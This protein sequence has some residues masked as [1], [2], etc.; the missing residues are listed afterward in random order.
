MRRFHPGF[1]VLSL[2]LAASALTLAACSDTTTSPTRGLSPSAADLSVTPGTNSLT[3]QSDGSTLFCT[4]E[5]SLGT[6]T[7][8]AEGYNPTGCGAGTL[9][10]MAALAVYNPGWSAPITGSDWIGITANGGP[11]SD[12]RAET[13]RYVFQETFTIPTGATNITLSLGAMADNAVAVYLN[14][15][16]L[17]GQTI[18]D[19]NAAPCN[20]TPAG[21]LNVTGSGATFFADGVTL[22]RLT[23]VLINTPIGYPLLTGPLGGP[24]PSYGCA[25]APQT[26]GEA[27]FSGVFNVPTSPAHLYAGRTTTINPTTHIGC[28]NPTGADFKGTVSWTTAVTTWCSPGFWKNHEE[29]WTSL[30][31]VKYSTLVGAADLSKKAPAGDPTIQQVIENPQIYGGP[32]TNSVADYL[33]NHFFGTP[34][35]SGV[36][37]CPS[38]DSPLFNPRA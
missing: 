17:G 12:Y 21:Q 9:D 38:P 16:L 2:A 18:T 26:N 5:Q 37:S 36:E 35:G 22:N 10:L 11:S 27:G 29:L 32:A 14:G 30:L 19:C 31:N 3:I 28:E 4:A 1:S 33:S 20:W 24:A 34:I 23:V 7:Y 8:P 13:G 15:H 25:R 6:Y